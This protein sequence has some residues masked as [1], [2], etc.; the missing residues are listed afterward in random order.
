MPQ[1][2]SVPQIQSL[3]S[4]HIYIVAEPGVLRAQGVR[5]GAFVFRFMDVYSLFRQDGIEAQPSTHYDRANRLL[6]T[7]ERPGFVGE[8]RMPQCSPYPDHK[9]VSIL[10]GLGNS[11]EPWCAVIKGNDTLLHSV[12]LVPGRGWVLPDSVDVRCYERNRTGNWQDIRISVSTGLGTFP[13]LG[14]E[15][16][17]EVHVVQVAIT[18]SSSSVAT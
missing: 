10:C 15:P 3:A 4:G 6:F 16:E 18:R 14:V 17:V 9:P 8:I 13:G 11:L 7:L 5:K 12:T 2:Q 1:I